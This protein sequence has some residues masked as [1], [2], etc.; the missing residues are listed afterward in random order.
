MT[1]AVAG[2]FGERIP[3]LSDTMLSG[4]ALS[5][6]DIIPGQLK[7]IVLNESISVSYS[8][9][10]KHALGVMR[11]AKKRLQRGASLGG[12]LDQLAEASNDGLDFIVAAHRPEA[13]L[14]HVGEGRIVAGSSYWIGDSQAAAEMHRFMADEPRIP[15]EKLHA[16]VTEEE[17]RFTA[18]FVALVG[19]TQSSIVGGFAICCLGSPYGHCYQGH[20]VVESR[21]PITIPATEAELLA[22]RERERTG[23]KSSSYTAVAPSVRGVAVMGAFMDYGDVGFIYSPLEMDEVEKYHPVTLEGLAAEV[24]THAKRVGEATW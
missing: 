20:T 15:P 22:R 23:M 1:L 10:M 2:V 3:M 7:S 21:E 12:L 11:V 18:A 8:G 14:Y 19:E 9:T 16:V 17:R 6:S 5:R 13:T 4:R 24:E